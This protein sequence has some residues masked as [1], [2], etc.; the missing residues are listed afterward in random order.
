VRQHRGIALSALSKVA[1]S[2]QLSA[3][4]HLVSGQ[5]Q[6][7]WRQVGRTRI[8]EVKVQSVNLSGEKPSAGKVPTVTVDVCWDVSKVDVLDKRGR[9]VVKH[10]R[11]DTGWTRYTVANYHW[12]ENR[13]GGWRIAAGQDLRQAPCAAS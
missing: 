9:S 13:S 7:G 10:D 12:S 3:E 4:Q 6:E 8:A 2:T 11:A 5:R 1:T